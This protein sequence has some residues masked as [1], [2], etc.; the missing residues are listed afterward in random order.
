M[1][2]REASVAVEGVTEAEYDAW[3]DMRRMAWPASMAGG[4]GDG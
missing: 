4:L 2:L 1:G 3:V